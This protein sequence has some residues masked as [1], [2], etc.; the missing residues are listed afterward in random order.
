MSSIYE[1]ECGS[2]G[3]NND[4]EMSKVR[5]NNSQIEMK[6]DEEVKLESSNNAMMNI[7]QTNERNEN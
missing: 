7:S 6:L 3:H 1:D 4:L 5:T 2:G